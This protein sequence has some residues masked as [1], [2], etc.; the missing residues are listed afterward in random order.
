MLRQAPLAACRP[1]GRAIPIEEAARQRR[2]AHMQEA[3]LNPTVTSE[4]ADE[5]RAVAL[6]A[7]AFTGEPFLRDDEDPATVLEPGT[8]RRDG[9]DDA[10]G[11]L[12]AGAPPPALPS[13]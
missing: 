5:L 4:A 12:A 3:T 7:Q 1:R 6:R 10:L 11:G 2:A 9:L 8:A 13:H